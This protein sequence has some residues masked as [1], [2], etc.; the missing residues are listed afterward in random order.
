MDDTDRGMAIEKFSEW[1]T[2]LAIELPSK[3]LP[4]Y[5]RYDLPELIQLIQSPLRAN[6]REDRPFDEPSQMA[7]ESSPGREPGDQQ[8]QLP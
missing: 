3:D 5:T 7:A 1:R 6:S 8:P 2:G 4:K